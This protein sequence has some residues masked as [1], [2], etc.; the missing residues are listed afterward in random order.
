VGFL[1]AFSLI[2]AKFR[3]IIASYDVM[4]AE[5]V[6]TA[7]EEE[8]GVCSD[9]GMHNLANRIS[10]KYGK[11][12]TILWV[13]LFVLWPV[14]TCF[15]GNTKN[16]MLTGF[17]PPS[18]EMLRKF[19]TDPNQNPDSWQGQNWEGRGYDIYAFFPE[20]PGGTGSNPKGNGDF[21][22]DY[23]DT[24]SDF[25]RIT[26][27]IHPIAILSYGKGT[28]SWELEYNARNLSVWN[29]DS[30]NPWQPTPSP[31]DSSVPAGY[32][33]NSTLPVQAIADAIDTSGAGVNAWVDWDGD[34]GAFL[35][36]YMAY[37]DAWYQS[38]H[39]DPC[40]QYR[41][42]AA[43]YTHVPGSLSVSTATTVCETALRTT[44]N[45]LD[46]QLT[47]YTI[48]GEVTSG[49]L[50]I[51][52][53]TINGLPGSL[54]TDANGFY[55]ATVGAGWSGKAAP[56]KKGYTFNPAELTCNNVRAD[57]LS[58]NYTAYPAE[59]QAIE[60][61]AASSFFSTE[62]SNTLSWSHTIGSGSNRMLVVATVSE[63][64]SAMRQVIASIKYNG[65]DMTALPASVKRRGY[66]KSELYYMTDANL[67]SS[68]GTYTVS[69]TYNGTVGSRAGGAISLKNVKQQF[70]ETVVTN[71]LA[72]AAA[73]STDINALSSGAWIIDAIGHSNNGSFSTSTS[74][75]QW[76]QNGGYH[77]GAGSTTTAASPGTTAVGWNFSGNSGTIIHSLAAFAP[78]QTVILEQLPSDNFDNNKRDNAVWQLFADNSENVWLV[79]DANRL[80]LRAAGAANNLVADYTARNW[81]IDVNENFRTKID[82]Y[83]SAAG[84]PGWVGMAIENSNNSYV[85]ISA[86]IDGNQP[87]YWYEQA[88]NGSVIASG[89]TPR[90][91]DNG[92]L[93][94]SYNTAA[95]RLYLSYNGYGPANAWQTIAGL[96]KGQWSSGPVSIS[97]GGGSDGGNID[98]NQ[99]YLDNFEVAAGKTQ[100]WPPAGDLNKDGLID[101]LD[102]KVMSEHWLEAGPDVKCDLNGDG[103]VNFVD[104]ACL[105]T[106]N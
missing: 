75:K 39:S 72:S 17:W 81:S 85:S 70:P 104:F 86:G 52:G 40:D 16:I 74:T 20:F 5:R 35:C 59:S 95:D 97:I 23:Q 33:R 31:P 25:W 83:Y 3:S 14:A 18:N 11:R 13:W 88:A 51:A 96:L 42:L 78:A 45:Y 46:S 71:S 68:P 92:K 101:E 15:A 69:I 65:V 87:Y 32:V 73:I 7:G 27:N 100:G 106:A 76:E 6:Y 82:F 60:F 2:L 49:D 12:R 30:L 48:S 34:A 64:N 93:Y 47:S 37:H 44:I 29:D 24:S 89:Q 21:E 84:G 80:N 62:W 38:Q 9:S 98:K 67:P 26:A 58:Q 90:A 19:S 41:C 1:T 77:T 63:D 94:V 79:E 22:V 66:I 99:A 53:V 55:S 102:V 36:E 61:D 28:N 10:L 54:V 105:A 8:E 56:V 57:R 43:G 50:P 91:S 103:I 4:R